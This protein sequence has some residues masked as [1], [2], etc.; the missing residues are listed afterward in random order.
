L[1]WRNPL[2]SGSL[3]GGCVALAIFLMIET[4]APSPMVPL[5]LFRSRS[6]LGANIFTLFLYAAVGIFFFL[7]PMDLIQLQ[8]YSATSAGSAMLPMILLMFL[9]SRWSGGL[10]KRYG[11]RIPLIIGPLIA[12][13]GFV[14][15]AVVR[16]GASYWQTYFPA[17]LA[18]GL[19]MAATVAPLT[20]VVMNSV[21]KQHA[22][23]ASGINNAVARVAAVLAIAVFGIVMV[24]RFDA[25]L[26]HR[27]TTLSLPRDTVQELRS[28]EADL[29]GL[30]LPEVLDGETVSA[31]QAAIS[32]SFLSG[33]RVVLLCCAG[34]SIAT[35]VVAWWLIGPATSRDRP[36]L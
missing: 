26:E 8:R 18:L 9:L 16:T 25:R 36:S 35:A 5:M 1:G 22:G 27:L 12:A 14:L 24:T 19:G 31:I 21:E 33:F 7:F 11:G 13:T 28:R 34:L 32:Q 4:K 6:F 23:T 15:F 30:K 29:A 17:S 2:V 3:L 20:T 10:V